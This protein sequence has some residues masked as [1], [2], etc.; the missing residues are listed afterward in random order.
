MPLKLLD[1]IIKQNK[2]KLIMFLNNNEHTEKEAKERVPFTM[3]SKKGK[4]FY[5]GTKVAK[6][7]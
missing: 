4:C 2:Q 6:E 7:L 3:T 1:V 5:L